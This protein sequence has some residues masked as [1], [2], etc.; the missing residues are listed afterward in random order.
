[1][2]QTIKNITDETLSITLFG[3]IYEIPSGW[4][5]TAEQVWGG[6]ETLRYVA[7][8]FADKI[9]VLDSAGTEVKEAICPGCNNKIIIK[10]GGGA[11]EQEVAAE[12]QGEEG[13]KEGKKRGRP[14][15]SSENK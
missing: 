5:L 7:V 3:H 11:E 8:K 13:K 1:M 10:S 9:K 6:E 12:E 2:I 4:S 15:G 14:K